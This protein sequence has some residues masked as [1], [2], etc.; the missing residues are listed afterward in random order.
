[1]LGVFWELLILGLSEETGSSLC[2]DVSGTVIRTAYGQA[3]QQR[4]SSFGAEK[5]KG[6]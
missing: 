1:M 5:L 3:G 4:T 6:T 2:M